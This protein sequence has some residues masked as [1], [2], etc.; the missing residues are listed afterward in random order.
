MRRERKAP[1][2]KPGI[3]GWP[4]ADR[5]REKLF[6]LGEHN[7]SDVELL[8]ILIG[9]GSP[10]EDALALARKIWARFGNSFREMSHTEPLAWQEFKGI[11]AAKLARVRAALEI[12]R[13][14][15][16]ETVRGR[17]RVSNPATL[18][19][20][21]MPRMRDLRKE[22]FKVVC[23][24]GRNQ[25][26]AVVEITEGTPNSANPPVREIVS[27]A[28]QNFSAGL[29]AV[30]NHPSGNPEPSREDREFTRRLNDICR[31][32]GIGFLDHLVIGDGKYYSFSESGQL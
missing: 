6:R 27:A 13:R 15:G 19:E 24:D 29:I 3:A 14:F 25:V 7:L 22:V 16:E 18:V 26:I 11:G 2:S 32:M 28:L 10:G 5:P 8:A 17:T 23:L 20:L 30:H 12:S 1:V 21:L 31:L 9:S 4:E